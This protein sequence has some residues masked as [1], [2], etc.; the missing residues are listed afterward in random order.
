M[1]DSAR[2][3]IMRTCHLLIG[4]DDVHEIR[5][6]KAGRRGTISGYFNNREALVEAVLPLDGT[7][8]AIYITLNPVNP[9]LLARAANRLR[10]RAESTTADTDITRRRWLL[11]DFDPVRPAGISSS[12][13]EHGRA[14]TVAC[15][16]WDDLRGAGLG[17]PVV[18]DSGNGAHLSY[19]LDL[20]NDRQATEKV[21]H[22]LAGVAARCGTDDIAVDLTVFNAA[23][24]VK[25]YG[26]MAC[27][28][29]STPERP[30]RRSRLLEIPSSLKAR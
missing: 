4:R 12:N 17:D 19:P 25:L 5:I 24:I 21:K 3:E 13:D 9:A 7:V 8:E 27:K 6:P 16:A 1:V 10:D 28:G 29:D 23:R 26:T 2:E 11:L 20:R 22:I 30:H 14:I 18:A 15:G